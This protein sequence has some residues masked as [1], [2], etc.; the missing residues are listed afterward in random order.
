MLQQLF[1]L[2]L[3]VAIM[4]PLTQCDP[5][6]NNPE[7]RRVLLLMRHAKAEG[8]DKPDFERGLK[9]RGKEDA[10]LMARILADKGIQPDYI[11]SSASKR[12]LATAKWVTKVWDLPFKE[13]VQDSGLY[14][15]TARELIDAVQAIP[16]NYKVVVL[17]GH[18]PSIIEASNHFQRDT[19]FMQ[20]PTSGVVAIEFYGE[21]WKEAR[22]HRSRLL[23]YDYP[24][25]HK[26]ATADPK[27]H[28]W[29]LDSSAYYRALDD[30]DNPPVEE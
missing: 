7:H 26:D 6:T 10:E 9:E 29:Q 4:G 3:L 1:K 28:L 22:H 24:K 19:I 8:Y 21:T 12:T 15:C 13:V 20:V 30:E 2:I 11:L 25:L 14:H 27:E 17:I 23:F 18:N 5:P 16:A